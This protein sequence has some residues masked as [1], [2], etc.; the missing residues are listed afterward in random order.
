MS[1]IHVDRVRH[2]GSQ[3]SA[4]DTADQA[5]SRKQDGVMDNSRHY[6][7]QHLIQSMDIEFRAR[8]T[9]SHMPFDPFRRSYS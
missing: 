1:V 8:C 9:S 2:Y 6:P 5:E 3:F 7:I 4:P